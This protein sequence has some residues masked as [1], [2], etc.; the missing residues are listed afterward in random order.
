MKNQQLSLYELIDRIDMNAA[1]KAAVKAQVRK[2]ELI[3]DFIASASALIGR[4]LRS[5]WLKLQ[6]V[7]S[8][9]KAED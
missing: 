2:F 5:L 4:G 7:K 3:G 9:L 8:P 1:D 6:P